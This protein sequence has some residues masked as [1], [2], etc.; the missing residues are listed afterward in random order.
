MNNEKVKPPV[1]MVNFYQEV[2]RLLEFW[3]TENKTINALDA[4]GAVDRL[5]TGGTSLSEGGLVNIDGVLASKYFSELVALILSKDPNNKLGLGLQQA[6][7]EG[8]FEPSFWLESS[9]VRDEQI[10][11]WAE[12]HGLEIYSLLRLVHF[13]WSPFWRQAGKNYKETLNQ[14]TWKQ[15]VCPICGRLPNLAILNEAEHGR[16]YLVCL[17]CDWQW[18]Y[19][20]TSCPTC[21]NDDHDSV[22]YTLVEEITRYKIFH[23][24]KCNSYLKTIDRRAEGYPTASSLF[25]EDLETIFLDLIAKQRGFLPMR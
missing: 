4:D 14:Q 2:E 24:E 12:N 23:C 21:D 25:I 20:R 10:A 1:A 15:G 9:P 17:S 16:R 5:L 8:D 6:L 18:A 19:S 13:A 3:T 22:G 11:T 7:V